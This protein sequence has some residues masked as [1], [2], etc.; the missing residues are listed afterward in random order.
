LTQWLLGEGNS[1]G[2]HTGLSKCFRLDLIEEGIGN[3]FK[4]ETQYKRAFPSEGNGEID[5]GF[6]CGCEMLQPRH[7]QAANFSGLPIY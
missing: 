5:S 7:T 1:K 4:E 6:P 3:M 2:L